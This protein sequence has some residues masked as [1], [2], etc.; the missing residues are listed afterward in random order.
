[1]TLSG[2]TALVTGASAPRG[3]GQAIA[4]RLAQDGARVVLTDIGTDTAM[5][6]LEA[7][8][9]TIAADGGIA[10]AHPLD[11]TRANAIAAVMSFA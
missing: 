8:V 9:A 3:I 1:M 10:L 2:Q 4:R 6:G 11:V 7:V 5:A